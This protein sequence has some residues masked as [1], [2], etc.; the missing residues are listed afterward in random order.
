[1]Q[2]AQLLEA[3][4]ALVHPGLILKTVGM[5]GLLI[6]ECRG[7]VGKGSLLD[8]TQVLGHLLH[9]LDGCLMTLQ[10]GLDR[11][12]GT[13]LLLSDFLQRSCVL[14][15]LLQ[16]LLV[17]LRGLLRLGDEL[18]DQLLALVDLAGNGLILVQGLVLIHEITSI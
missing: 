13:L 1:L 10:C 2:E 6:G 16:Q 14:L 5:A 12:S 4:E 11:L 7:N 8:L 15:L 17:H 9:L 3:F 18:A